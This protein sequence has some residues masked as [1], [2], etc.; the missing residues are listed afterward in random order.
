M[1]LIEKVVEKMFEDAKPIVMDYS[2]DPLY[3]IYSPITMERL[4]TINPQLETKFKN[5]FKLLKIDGAYGFGSIETRKVTM[6]IIEHLAPLIYDYMI[7]QVLIDCD[8][9][10]GDAVFHWLGHMFFPS[11]WLDDIVTMLEDTRRFMLMQKTYKDYEELQEGDVILEHGKVC[12]IIAKEG[13][14]VKY[15]LNNTSFYDHAGIN[16]QENKKYYLHPVKDFVKKHCV[17]GTTES[18]DVKTVDVNSLMEESIKAIRCQSLDEWMEELKSTSDQFPR[19]HTIIRDGER[20]KAEGIGVEYYGKMKELYLEWYFANLDKVEEYYRKEKDRSDLLLSDLS[21]QERNIVLEAV[22]EQVVTC[23]YQT[24]YFKK[25]DKY[26][27]SPSFCTYIDSPISDAITKDDGRI[28]Q[29]NF[30]LANM[31]YLGESYFKDKT[32]IELSAEKE[33]EQ[34]D[35]LS[36][37]L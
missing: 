35:L 15:Y 8:M 37:A 26:Y 1:D 13:L 4:Q 32:V 6:A 21:Y 25:R 33:A 31:K 17:I 14:E 18:V 7:G 16:D 22:K 9:D 23:K 27:S 5:A 3:S 30:I 12:S 34:L 28:D 29:M 11:N 24:V 19:F 2:M 10:I 20:Y 36:L